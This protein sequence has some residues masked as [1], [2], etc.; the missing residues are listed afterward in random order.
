MLYIIVC[1]YWLCL[2]FEIV[3]IST[4]ALQQPPTDKTV[5]SLQEVKTSA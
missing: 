2:T 4:L 1:L 3:K 5:Q